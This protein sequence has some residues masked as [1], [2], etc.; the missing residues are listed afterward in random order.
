MKKRIIALI[1]FSPYSENL[2]KLAGSLS[3]TMKAEIVLIHQVPGIAPALADAKSRREL[4]ELEKSEA[5][6]NLKQAS[7][8]I[9]PSEKKVNYLATERPLSVVLPELGS[10]NSDDLVL[11]GL[12]G[13]GI[14][15]KIFIG[16]TT[17]KI[18]EDL[19]V[20]TVAVPVKTDNLELERLVIATNYRY[21]LN[22]TAL[23]NL[24]RNFSEIVDE[25][26][27]I[28]IITPDDN[29]VETLKYLQQ[30]TEHYQDRIK[31]NFKMYKGKN[32][33][34]EIKSLM[35]GDNRSFLVV[36]KGSRTI[37]DQVFREFLINDLV[38][39]GS[40]PLII[41]P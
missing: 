28:S 22:K 17:L 12:K 11:V 30:L 36:Q 35:K 37:N 2:I 6:R 14:L 34:E 39:Q 8:K 24:L 38:Y 29:D 5:L 4:I 16:S 9:I 33:F 27:F 32:A 41:F 7:E 15:K 40:I 1:D 25:L 26:L 10:R 13:T 3:D 31:S 18:I 23:D 19:A 21:P 20:T